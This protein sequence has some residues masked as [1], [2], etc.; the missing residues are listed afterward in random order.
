M[1]VSA[2]GSEFDTGRSSKAGYGIPLGEAA[3]R[4]PARQ[5]EID[6]RR[7]TRKAERNAKKLETEVDTGPTNAEERELRSTEKAVED[8]IKQEEKNQKLK[9]GSR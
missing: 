7:A 8:R 6:T 2:F 5:Q 9:G 3:G 4:T 1:A